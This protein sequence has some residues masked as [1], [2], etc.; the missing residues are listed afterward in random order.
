ME[1]GGGRWGSVGVGGGRWRSVEVGGGMGGCVVGVWW[2][3]GGCVV[4]VWW[5]G[6]Q[7]SNSQN[8]FHCNYNGTENAF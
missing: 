1:V 6:A 8:N 3:C 5:V 4:G 2:V 7:Y